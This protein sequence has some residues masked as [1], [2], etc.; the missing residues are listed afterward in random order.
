M[1]RISYS[2]ASFLTADA[3]ADTLFQ[4]VTALSISQTTET[5]NLP[6]INVTGKTI[7]VTLIVGPGSELISVP[8]DSLWDEPDITE[9]VFFLRDHIH[10]LHRPKP[11]PSYSE[12]ANTDFDSSDFDNTYTGLTP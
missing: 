3:L 12:I 6:A 5:L 9:V 8:E 1:R 11:S 2:G 7:I 10:A 4:L